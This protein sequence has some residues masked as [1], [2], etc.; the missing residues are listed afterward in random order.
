MD[1]EHCTWD[2]I[3]FVVW[4]LIVVLLLVVLC[5]TVVQARRARRRRVTALERM[6]ALQLDLERQ[7]QEQGKPKADKLDE[8]IEKWRRS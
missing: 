3:L 2:E 7:Q 4:L 6:I 8:A 1:M 5:F